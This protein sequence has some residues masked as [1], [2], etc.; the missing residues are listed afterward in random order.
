METIRIQT[1][2]NVTIEYPLASIN[3]RMLAYLLDAVLI[4]AYLVLVFGIVSYLG[5]DDMPTFV[6]ILLYLPVIFYDLVSEILMNGQSFGKRQL[7]IKVIKTDGSQAGLSSYFLRWFVGFFEAHGFW[8]AIA[9][10]A[11]VAG[12]TGQRLGDMAAGTCVVK[13][14]E[15]TLARPPKIQAEDESYEPMFPQ[16]TVLSDKDIRILQEVLHFYRINRN[17]KPVMALAE[18]LKDLL[19]L[20]EVSMPPLLMLEQMLKD[21]NYLTSQ[22][23]S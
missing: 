4:I 17:S 1:A 22:E 19:K 7:Q 6:L 8:A 11:I 15:A 3:D 16:I 18:R 13:L 20:E 21:Y 2:T 12:G 10:L 5:M 14:R 23:K 9:L